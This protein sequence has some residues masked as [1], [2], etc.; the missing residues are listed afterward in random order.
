MRKI[1]KLQ[2][3]LGDVLDALYLVAEASVCLKSRLSS[4]WPKVRIF[5]FASRIIPAV[6]TRGWHFQFAFSW[7]AVFRSSQ[8]AN[9]HTP[10]RRQSPCRG[11]G[12]VR[13]SSLWGSK[14]RGT[15]RCIDARRW[16]ICEA[17]MCEAQRTTGTAG[18]VIGC[19]PLKRN[20]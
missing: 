4:S 7:F 8:F 5:Y 3:S 10:Q 12:K 2:F 6:R 18:V 20:Y 9:Y 14:M 13:G 1:E 11:G 17:G 16:V 19:E 15:V